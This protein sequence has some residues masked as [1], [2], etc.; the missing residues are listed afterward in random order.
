[1]RQPAATAPSV[2]QV[3][4]V[5]RE[6][7]I[8]SPTRRVAK[9]LRLASDVSVL[10]AAFVLAYLLRFEFSPPPSVVRSA[11]LQ[12]AFVVPLQL[13]ALR[14]SGVH[15]FVWRYV[16][17]REVG[18]FGQAALWSFGPLLFLRVALPDAFADLRVPVS[19]IVMDTVL[20]FG[21][22]LA[23]RVMRRAVHERS[24][25]VRHAASAVSDRSRPILLA[26]AGR[27]GVVTAR[28]IQSH[29]GSDLEIRGFVDDD[30]Q[31]VGTVIQGVPVLGTCA[32][33][34][35]LVRDLGIDHVVMSV[36][37]P[38]RQEVRQLRKVCE[39]IPVR[40]RIIPAMHEILQ[41]RVTVSRI[42]DLQ[43]EDLLG[44]APVDLDDQDVGRLLAGN[45]VL[46]TGAGGSIGSE[47]AR[48][49]ARFAPARLL[50]AERAEFALFAIDRELREMLPSVR[51]VPLVA[52]VADRD[53]M[54]GIFAEHA[55]ANRPPRG[56]P[57]ARADDGVQPDRSRQEQRARDAGA[58]R[59]RRHVRRHAFVMISTD[60]AVRPTSVMGA[61]KRVAELVIQELD[62]RYPTRFVAVRFGNV[63]GSAG[64]VITLFREEIRRGG[65]VKVTHPSMMRYFM[66]IP[67]A[68]Q[69]VL[70]AATLGR[71]GEIF[72]LDMGEPVRIL[73][74]A[75]DTIAL[76]GL[77]PFE[78][79]EIVFTGLRPGEKLFEELEKTDEHLERTRHPKIFIGRIAAYSEEAVSTAR[80]RLERIVADGRP[81]DVYA[82]LGEFLPEAQLGRP[83]G[84]PVTSSA[85]GAPVPGP[86]LW[87][88][89][90]RVTVAPQ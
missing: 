26:G 85:H 25:R 87:A 8:W 34:P 65:P 14:Y 42:R 86:A 2:P 48:Q 54:H 30:P 59:D 71:G 15:A 37:Q 70:Q 79:I 20:A 80:R 13:A 67:E 81:A 68:S 88:G 3:F 58:R 66:T 11:L 9:V 46:V 39:S 23:L 5:P 50:L 60:K 36:A 49:V 31:K 6:I 75:K 56:C 33:L 41:E 47:L 28:E 4:E 22:T 82:F 73:D 12:L 18:A 52:D 21:G 55:P 69:L 10:S 76:S 27:V 84:E 90:A 61:T 89:D 44:R 40:L 63:I 43:V 19:V 51:I 53:R 57:Q 24:V 64:S 45:T 32:D 35:R 83:P 38:T 29:P 77:R 1:M 78:D 16:G 62:A 72:V 7:R 74:L 17:M